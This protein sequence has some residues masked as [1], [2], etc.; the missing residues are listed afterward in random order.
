MRTAS[1]SSTVRPALRG[2]AAAVPLIAARN[3]WRWYT[4]SVLRA[5]NDCV[6][7]DH[8][9]AAAC[10]PWFSAT[11]PSNTHAGSGAADSALPA[12][13]SSLTHSATCFQPADCQSSNGP[14]FQ[15]KPQRIARSMSAAEPAICSR[16]TAM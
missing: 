7:G 2:S 3:A 5:T 10:T 15:P 12:S 9:P 14:E 13:T 4:G 16:Y 1:F 6:A 8:E 11:G